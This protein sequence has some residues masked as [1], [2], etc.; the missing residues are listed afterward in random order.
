MKR[1]GK[2]TKRGL[3]TVITA[4]ILLSATAV[5]GVAVVSLSSSSINQAPSLENTLSEKL[6]VFKE[7]IFIEHYWLAG[8]PAYLSKFVNITVT[9]IGEVG[10]RI[11]DMEFVNSYNGTTLA[12]F[13]VIGDLK[14]KETV[15]FE[16]GYN[17]LSET[18]FD[19]IVTTARGNSYQ[20]E[21]VFTKAGDSDGDG[22]D[23]DVDN[24]P[25]VPN[26]PQTDSNSDG[27]GDVCDNDDDGISDNIEDLFGDYGINY[28]TG[29]LVYVIV[30]SDS[31]IEIKLKDVGGDQFF[32]F[33]FPPGTQDSGTNSVDLT[34]TPGIS[35]PWALVEDAVLPV[36]LTK[37]ITMPLPPTTNDAVC[38]TDK[39]PP[40]PPSS[41]KTQI[42][43]FASCTFGILYPTTIGPPGNS[44]INP[45][46]GLLNT[47][48]KNSDGT[49][50][51]TGLKNTFVTSSHD[52]E[53]DKV[54][55]AV[56]RR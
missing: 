21:D 51:I 7:S 1:V 39:E 31:S 40:P 17:W 42:R 47:V 15:S 45:D 35:I 20:I 43:N 12:S 36:G 18:P 41:A 9:N 24:C 13:S 44:A 50:T 23:D 49:I 4:V 54:R 26:S 55:Y 30:F 37:T 6:N 48:I 3:S 25:S 53:M 8:P 33:K 29:E 11:T 16:Q 5:M 27:V 28:L 46:T 56:N 52:N 32:I 10:I 14:P 34:I 2:G 22:I 19:V 38:I